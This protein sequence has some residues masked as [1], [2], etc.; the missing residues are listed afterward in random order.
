MGRRRWLRG[1]GILVACGAVACAALAVWL[2]HDLPSPGD[3]SAHTA[4][5]SSRIY[6]RHG[7][8]L[9]E[10]PP[11]YTG[12]HTP[13]DLRDIPLDLRHATVALE[14]ASFYRNPG[15]DPVGVARS[16]WYNLTT[17][18][19]VM[20]GSTITQQ[21]ARLLLLPEE[22]FELTLRRKLREAFL[23]V[24][25]TLR[26][27]KDEIFSLYLNEVYYGNMAYGAGA[28]ARAYFGKDVAALDLAECAMLA[29]LPQAP[30]YW[31]PLENLREARQRQAIALDRMVAEGYVETSDAEMAK[32]EDLTFVAAPFPIRAPHFVM[33]VRAQL[34]RSLGLDRL[35]SG[36]LEITTTL[37]VDL[38]ERV[39]DLMRHRLALLAACNHETPCP[40]G[41]YNVRNAAVVALDPA[42][43]EILAMVGSP[44]Y[45]SGRIDGAVNGTT[46]LRQPGSSIKP[47]TYAAAFAE[48]EMT[49]ATVLM[50]VRTAFTTHEGTPYVPLNYDLAFRGPVRLREALASSYNVVAV[51]VLDAVGID[52]LASLAGDMGITSFDDPDRL[53]LALTLGGGEVRPLEL[54]AA[55]AAF[56]N[57]GYA[58]AP[59]AIR[60]VVDA[61]GE[62]LWQQP[63]GSPE[64]CRRDRVLDERVAYQ[65]T[66]ILSD[67]QARIPTYG[68]ESV[69][70]LTRPAA[71]KTGTTTDFRDNWTVGYTPDLVVGVWVGNA[72]NE[73]MHKVSGITGAA[74]LWRDAMEAAHLGLPVRDFERPDGLVTAEV[75][76]LSGQLPGPDC[77][78]HVSELFIEGTVPDGMCSMHR[79]V[80]DEVRL[81]LPPEAHRWA[82][83]HGVP[84]WLPEEGEPAGGVAGL[85]L[86]SPDPGAV[87]KI[88]PGTPRAQQRIRVSAASDVPLARVA[89]LVDGEPLATFLSL[90]YEALW[91]LVPGEH[92]FQ[93]QGEDGEGEVTDTD[94]VWI[95]VKP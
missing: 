50:D 27:S 90:P 14:D 92:S 83:S 73:A 10:M 93:A 43:G 4:A 16:V 34:E 40:P 63:C 11:P 59:Q 70:R 85:A 1:L 87:F 79:R 95:T 89:L 62:V 48:A 91:Q 17:D 47:I 35:E 94:L 20:G 26:Y 71:A 12:M 22:R 19:Y 46:A 33:Y 67:D 8:L 75:C 80:G 18:D 5:P 88:D 76:A 15:V 53:G 61:D 77:A 51:K 55:Y 45:F 86:I 52:A 21:L 23:A 28:A 84:L 41:G 32:A 30:A 39:R 57:G 56:A 31:N 6:D 78:H 49:P 72:D 9:Y 64:M 82:L 66:D 69:L 38:N 68:E 44:D 25:I 74:P 7:R 60:S 3:L 42:T 36:G 29:I 2:F 24:R 81:D 54:A 13:V 58:V 37:D 65:I